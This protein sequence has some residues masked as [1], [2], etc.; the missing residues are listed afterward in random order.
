MKSH[1]YLSLFLL[2]LTIVF[3]CSLDVIIAT[4]GGDGLVLGCIFFML[5]CL[6][7]TGT[8]TAFVDYLATRNKLNETP[9][10]IAADFKRV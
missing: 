4:K 8:L 1:F 7:F 10:P 5:G 9:N 3:G 6:T 2:L